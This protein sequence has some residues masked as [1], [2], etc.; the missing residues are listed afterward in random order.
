MTRLTAGVVILAL[1]GVF[2]GT[3]AGQEDREAKPAKPA[4]AAPLAHVVLIK[5]KADAPDGAADELIADC[6]KM[7]GKIPTVRGLKAGR[8]AKSEGPFLKKDYD[9]GLLIL[10]ADE[11]GLKAYIDHDL[12]KAFV[13]KHAPRFAKGGLRVFDFVD[14][15]K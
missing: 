11:K 15:K 2:A 5:L 1:A 10:F 7:L 12:H 8:P 6:H 3:V 9:V 4:A 14:G 13:K